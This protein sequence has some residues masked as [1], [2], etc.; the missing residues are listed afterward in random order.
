M[1]VLHIVYNLSKRSGV[2]SFIMNLYR[3]TDHTKIQFDFLV[4]NPSDVSYESEIK[5]MGGTVFFVQSPLSIKT[6]FSSISQINNF[7]KNNADNYSVVHLHTVTTA[8][9]TLRLAKKYGIKK[10]IVHSH[11]TIFS[12]NKLKNFM[13][14]LLVI[15]LKNYANVFWACSEKAGEFLYGKRFMRK[16]NVK[17][18]YNAIDCEEYKFNEII[19]KEYRKFMGLTDNFVIGHVGRFDDIKNQTF[20]ICSFYDVIQKKENAVLILVGIGPKL[21]EVKKLVKDKGIEDRVL[22]LGYREDIYN[23]MQAIDI[24]VLPSIKE[25]LPVVAV[26]AQASG[27]EC[28]LSSSITRE[29]N[30]GKI[31][32]LDLEIGLWNNALWKERDSHSHNRYDAYDVIKSS[33]FNMKNEALRVEK[34]YLEINNII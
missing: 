19:R 25:G 28:I 20:L 15:N 30:L 1:R 32:Y 16:E 18:I 8:F 31:E 4:M 26:E 3:N 2:S 22:F 9:V 34:Y 10:R 24:F 12:Q 21:E 27:L 7:F 33:V 6:I 14:H 11:S 23:I 29:V 17:I 13:H 5:K